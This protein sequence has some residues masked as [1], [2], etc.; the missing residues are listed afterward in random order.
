MPPTE[1]KPEVG[2]AALRG[3]PE[4]PEP[5][6]WRLCGRRQET[7]GMR[8]GVAGAG[9]LLALLV[10][11]DPVLPVGMGGV[12]WAVLA[13]GAKREKKEIGRDPG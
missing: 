1:W 7:A 4:T 5:Q 11:G 13:A 10:G 2:R 9:A 6:S 8:E 12:S 3:V